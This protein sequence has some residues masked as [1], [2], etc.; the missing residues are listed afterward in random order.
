M[1][2]RC[3][4]PNNKAW[5]YYGGRGISVCKEW[6]NDFVRFFDDMKNGYRPGLT[7]ERKNN[8]GNYSPSNC[9]WATWKEQ[10][11]NQRPRT[12]AIK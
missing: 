12:K 1:K 9:T 7:I 11:Q 6:K 4:N 8:N 3:A 2:T 5:K 10:M